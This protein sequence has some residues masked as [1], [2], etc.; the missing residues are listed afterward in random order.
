MK[1]CI[2][3]L[4][5]IGFF[6]VG[7]SQVSL[8]EV[9]ITNLNINSANSDFGVSFDEGNK[10]IFSSSRKVSSVVKIGLNPSKSSFLDLFIG[11]MSFL[12]VV[13]DV[14]TFSKNINSKFHES[15]VSFSPDYNT[16]Y[17]TR[18]NF[19]NGKLGATDA[20]KNIVLKLYK[21]T[22]VKGEWKNVEELPFNSDSYSVGHPSVSSD[23]KK[24]YFTS[25]MP[26]SIGL[27]DIF[28]VDVFDGQGY[29][30][31]RNL[32]PIINT[33]GK[34]M[35]PF[36]DGNNTLYFSSNGREDNLGGLDIYYSTQN[37][38]NV[39]NFPVNIGS[40]LNSTADDFS[41]VRLKNENSGYFASNRYGGKGS[42]DIYAFEGVKLSD[43]CN[44]KGIVADKNL[45][46]LL[47]NAIIN[48]YRDSSIIAQL[49]TDFSGKFSLLSDCDSNYEIEVKK[50]GY[51][52]LKVAVTIENE[53]K[54]LK[55]LLFE[56]KPDILEEEIVKEKE[57]GRAYIE[58]GNIYFAYDQS[59][60]RS[61]EYP[62]LDRLV[63][64]M[65]KYPAIKVEI[66]SHTDSRG[67]KIYNLNLSD[68]RAKST[69]D[70]IISKGISEERIF[71]RGYGES[72]PINS[73]S[74]AVK[75]TPLEYQLNR[76]TEFIILNK[77]MLENF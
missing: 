71:A 65:L 37:A 45:N 21:A 35:F 11:K 48:V 15:S 69:L 76:R 28:V 49:R 70:Y 74:D 32:G 68:L 19:N 60:I 3:I 13:D 58:I 30:E 26:G 46:K 17:F 12:T 16:I 14:R 72:Q 34:E 40:P 44:M 47:S 2:I 24:L 36:I 8:D 55:I 52:K 38:E 75:C 22:K 27:T 9:T 29:S 10:I 7:F 6:N 64:I 51:Q 53:D 56:K 42:D 54:N 61:S 73:C 50:K 18:N 33:R 31:P 25:D 5:W 1:K 20:N 4:I 63:A 57:D 43:K 77:N 67:S 59:N 66:G 39:F 23:G 62:R 41:F